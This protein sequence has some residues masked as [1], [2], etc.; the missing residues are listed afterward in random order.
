MPFHFFLLYLFCSAS[1]SPSF[2]PTSFSLFLFVSVY[3]LM[4][5]L[6]LSTVSLFSLHPL[7]LESIFCLPTYFSF[8]SLFY[9]VVGISLC[10]CYLLLLYLFFSTSPLIFLPIYFSWHDSLLLVSMYFCLA[11]ISL[12]TR[13]LFL[14]CFPFLFRMRQLWQGQI[15]KFPL[16]FILFI[17]HYFSLFL[18][19]SFYQ[20]VFIYALSFSVCHISFQCFPSLFKL[21]SIIHLSLWHFP[22]IASYSLSFF[23]LPLCPSVFHL[24]FCVTPIICHP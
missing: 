7:S 18:S 1:P 9:L 11:F 8:I 6:S 5:F 21:S 13:S 20:Y 2:H 4:A 10:S 23:S 17:Y 15:S 24:S 16:F 12:S 22:C 14:W 3:F 19:I